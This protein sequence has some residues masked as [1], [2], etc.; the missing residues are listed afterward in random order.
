MIAFTDDDKIRAASAFI[1]TMH[2]VAGCSVDEIK[3]LFDP[4]IID[5]VIDVMDA[6]AKRKH[7]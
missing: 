6:Q 5:A 3:R 4:Q 7:Q 2:K 1:A